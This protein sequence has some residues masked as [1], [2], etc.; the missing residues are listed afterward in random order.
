MAKK[1]ALIGDVPG[2]IL[3]MLGDLTQKLL[4]E[5]IAVSELGLF[6]K[7][8]SPFQLEVISIEPDFETDMNA[9]FGWKLS[10]DVDRPKEFVI[11]EIGTAGLCKPR[12]YLKKGEP[13][14]Y[15]EVLMQRAASFTNLG[16]RHAEAIIRKKHLIPLAWWRKRIIF[17]GTE[18]SHKVQPKGVMVPI[19]SWSDYHKDFTLDFTQI[20]DC[21]YTNN[22]VLATFRKLS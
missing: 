2:N 13:Y 19:I 21:C 10:K 4:H 6:L 16:Q 7:R 9:K 12:G 18:W 11:Q 1:Q 15:G 3:G 8:Q 14:I 20:N 17:A 5:G 22:D